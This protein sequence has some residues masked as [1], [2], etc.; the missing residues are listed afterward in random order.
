MLAKGMNPTSLTST[1]FSVEDILKQEHHHIY[2]NGVFIL[3]HQTTQVPQQATHRASRSLDFFDYQQKQCVP[4][5]MQG[6]RI[7]KG[8]S[9]AEEELSNEGELS[10]Q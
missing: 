4:G 7:M 1:P 5:M 10:N 8:N 6:K 2:N 9:S 3:P